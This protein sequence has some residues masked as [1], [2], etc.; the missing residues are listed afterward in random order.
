MSGARADDTASHVAD[1]LKGQRTPHAAMVA[2]H[3]ERRHHR[4]HVTTTSSPTSTSRSWLHVVFAELPAHG[5]QHDVSF[6]PRTRVRHAWCKVVG[7]APT[8]FNLPQRAIEALGEEGRVIRT[9]ATRR[10]GTSRE[11]EM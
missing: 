3:G 10:D 6:I 11:H 7:F 5:R 2:R 8:R 4:I 9:A 1:A